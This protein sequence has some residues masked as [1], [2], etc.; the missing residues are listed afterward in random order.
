M[1]EPYIPHDTET[2]DD[3]ELLRRIKKIALDIGRYLGKPDLG[4]ASSESYFAIDGKVW[5][6]GN[7]VAYDRGDYFLWMND[8]RAGK[9]KVIRPTAEK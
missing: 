3:P 9:I 1:T 8:V 7:R 5:L 4:Y 6:I 2:I